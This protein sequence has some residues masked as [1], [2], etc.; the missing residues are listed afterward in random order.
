MY[1]S[2][3]PDIRILRDIHFR[4]EPGETVAFVGPSGSGKST[5]AN[6]VPRFYEPD[7]GVIRIDGQDLRELQLASLRHHIGIVNQETILF[8][9]TVLDNLLLAN[10]GATVDQIHAA[11]DAANAREFVDDLPEGLWTEIGERGAMLSGG[12]KQRL[13]IARAFLKNPRILILDEATSALDS[14]SEHHIQQ[15]LDRLLKGRT[16][17]VIA[18]RLSTVRNADN[19]GGFIFRAA[20]SPKTMPPRWSRSTSG[21]TSAPSTRSKARPGSPTCSST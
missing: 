16:S 5:L 19:I 18:H 15:A 4:I 7:G 14:R 17:I 11:L 13:A 1:F 3:D 10:P 20:L 9:G 12:Q 2:Y 21:T 6:L 8:S